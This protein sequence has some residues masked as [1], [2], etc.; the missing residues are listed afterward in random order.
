MARVIVLGGGF[1]G[2]AAATAARRALDRDDEVML[3]ARDHQFAMGW[4]KIWALV[5]I[6]PLRESVRELG[7]LRERGID[8]RH[9]SIDVI[10]PAERAVATSEG[11]IEA[12]AI[13]VALGAD[14]DPHATAKFDGK[15]A[16]DLYSFAAIDAAS[17]ALQ[18]CDG[19]LVVLGV[20][21]QP[22]KCPPAPFEAALAID[23][24]LR[25]QRRRDDVDITVATPS[26]GALPVAGPEASA[27]IAGCL[28]DRGIHLRTEQLLAGIDPDAQTVTFGD[29]ERCDASL[30]FGVPAA[31]P[32]PVVADSPLAGEGGWIV[33]DRRTLGTGFP[34]VYA[35]GDCTTVPTATAAL[36]KAGVFAAAQGEVAA[37][38]VVA[39]LDRG[40]RAQFDG[41][42]HCYLEFPG[43]EVSVVAG[44][45][46]AEPKPD[47]TLSPPSAAAYQEKLDFEATRLRAWFG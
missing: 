46:F 6:R 10:D 4:T 27:T 32:P 7:Q 1:G 14:A 25:E 11:D 42:G 33:P 9:A 47:V 41:Y 26:P 22:I 37:A 28:D 34:R 44:N 43:R 30:V 5:G 23:A 2:I 29:A 45:F 31:V 18:A 12:D 40:P 20:M 13:I 24:Y 3:V 19:G 35:V 38:N 15:F 21:G 17:A 16:H 39:D 8:F 36:P